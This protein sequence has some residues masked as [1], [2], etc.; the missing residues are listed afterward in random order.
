[1]LI[2]R[3]SQTR[4]A[5]WPIAIAIASAAAVCQASAAVSTEGDCSASSGQRVTP[6]VELY[7]SE[8]CSSCPPA[9]R[10]ISGFADQNKA[11]SLVFHVDYWDYLGWSDRF[12]SPRFS[13]RQRQRVNQAG[14]RITYTP[15]V[16]IGPQVQVD[17]RSSSALTRAL[18]AAARPAEQSL[19]LEV[20]ALSTHLQIE[21]LRKGP[22]A[23]NAPSVLWLAVLEDGLSSSVSRGENAGRQLNHDRVVRQ[24]LGPYAFD[25]HQRLRSELEWETGWIRDQLH[26]VAWL[27]AA[28]SGQTLAAVQLALS[29]CLAR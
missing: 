14:G 27:E 2:H 28:D 3:S 5:W 25:S 10:W 20:S 6:V 7:T 9:D 23:A 24:W 4:E 15:Q 29:R 11:I 13:Q 17:W 1:M 8:G 18:Q 19:T 26:I 16:M 21:L 22:V 12:A